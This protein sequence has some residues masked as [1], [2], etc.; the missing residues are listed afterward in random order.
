MLRGFEKVL[1]TIGIMMSAA[2]VARVSTPATSIRV[3]S[4]RPVRLNRGVQ[5]ELKLDEAQLE[6]VEKIAAKVQAKGR[7]A[8]KEYQTLSKTVR[9]QKMHTL[10]TE[11]C[12][13]AMTAVVAA[14][15]RP[16][17]PS[18]SIRSCCSNE[19]SW[20]SPTQRSRPN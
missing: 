5:R 10:M 17:S 19:G 20:R 9:R 13:Q 3:A 16:S 7:A 2:V 4:R 18:V 1:L 8:A 14:S 6:K 11:A 12:E 15:S